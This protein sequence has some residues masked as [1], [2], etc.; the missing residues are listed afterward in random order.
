MKPK[1]LCVDDSRALRTGMKNWLQPNYEVVGSP[2]GRAALDLLE[3]TTFDLIIL[4]LDMPNMNGEETIRELRGRGDQTPV[5]LLTAEAK[6]SNIQ[7]VMQ[8]GVLDYILKPCS[9]PDLKVKLEAALRTAYDQ[10][11]ADA[12]VAANQ[13]TIEQAGGRKAPG[14]QP[15]AAKAPATP[16]NPVTSKAAAAPGPGPGPSG[17]PAPKEGA[18][19]ILVIDDM[20]SV[21]RA[22]RRD[23]RDEIRIGHATT[24]DAAVNTCTKRDYQMIVIDMDIPRVNSD[25]LCRELRALQPKGELIAL[26]LAS[27]ADPTGRSKSAGFDGFLL[28]PFLSEEV[29]ALIS[30]VFNQRTFFDSQDNVVTCHPIEFGDTNR[31]TVLGEAREQLLEEINKVAAAACF[32][33]V[34]LDLGGYVPLDALARFVGPV[35]ERCGKLRLQLKVVGDESVSQALA[36]TLE[37]DSVSVVAS[38]GDALRA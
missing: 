25:E 34:V 18:P 6:T 32:P 37:K 24:R 23:V 35:I 36:A 26:F 31:E 4:D 20:K 8:H 17:K 2:D 30:R 27:E 21:S 16:S 3:N 38:V 5:V 13:A 1:I 33:A 10:K 7:K 29:Q 9:P 28:K 14:P 15:A 22:L 12:Q 19:S 11:L